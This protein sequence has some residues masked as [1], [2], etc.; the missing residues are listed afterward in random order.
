ME[1]WF[2][3][4]RKIK[5]PHDRVAATLSQ[6][7]L[8]ECNTGGFVTYATEFGTAKMVYFVEYPH[9]FGMADRQYLL[10]FAFDQMTSLHAFLGVLATSFETNVSEHYKFSAPTSL[11]RVT[12]RFNTPLYYSMPNGVL[13]MVK[14]ELKAPEKNPFS[15]LKIEIDYS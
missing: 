7:R 11:L 15:D 10:D 13:P 2:S 4:I 5:D 3:Y 12:T 14:T 8:F 6:L 9:H 1:D